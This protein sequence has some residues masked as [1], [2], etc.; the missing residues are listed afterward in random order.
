MR[1]FFT[2]S[3][4]ALL[5]IV[6]LL[7]GAPANAGSIGWNDPEGDAVE[8]FGEAPPRPSQPMYDILKVA[9][10]SDGK[11]LTVKAGFKQLGSIP[12]QATGNVYRFAFTAGDGRFTLSIIE[13]HVGGNYSAFSVRDETTGV[14][15]AVECVKCF[16]KIN[17]ESNQVELKLP[18]RSLDSARK[19]AQVPGKIAAGSTLA[20]VTVLAGE[21]YNGGYSTGFGFSLSNDADS[22]PVPG[23]GKFTL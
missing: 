18:I 12:P 4:V 19:S 3:G 8:L 23:P 17:L 13:D 1:K 11:D 6:V 21:Y 15:N 20:E 10:S 14:N 7:N 2:A 9:M 16:G 5:A 22:A